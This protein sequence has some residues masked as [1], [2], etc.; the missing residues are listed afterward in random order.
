MFIELCKL[1]EQASRR[2]VLGIKMTCEDYQS[3][4]ITENIVARG[5]EIICKLSISFENEDMMDNCSEVDK[6]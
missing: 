1:E 4:N 2:G 3:N 5:S 6:V